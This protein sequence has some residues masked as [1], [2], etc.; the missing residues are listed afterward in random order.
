MFADPGAGVRAQ[1]R[2]PGRILMFAT[3]WFGPQLRRW[4]RF[5][6]EVDRL[7]DAKRVGGEV[8]AIWNASMTSAERGTMTWHGLVKG[9]PQVVFPGGDGWLY[10]FKAD[11]GKD[12]KPELLWKADLNPKDSVLILGGRGTRNDII[13]TPVVYEMAWDFTSL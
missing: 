9:E 11:Q 1:A 4:D 2:A 5:Q 12:G 7:D 3:F 6:E 13:G 8:D 10:S